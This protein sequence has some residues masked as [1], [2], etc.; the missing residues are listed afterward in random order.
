MQAEID[1]LRQEILELKEQETH[2]RNLSHQAQAEKESAVTCQNIA[3]GT[4][5]GAVTA[6]N[7]MWHKLVH[8]TRSKQALGLQLSS[9]QDEI[10]CLRDRIAEVCNRGH[11]LVLAP[12][13]PSCQ[14][15]GI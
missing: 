11:V 6:K 7:E 4:C 8:E 2:A 10:K 3:F 13:C 14:H 15:A 12:T 5:S 9:C 1:Q